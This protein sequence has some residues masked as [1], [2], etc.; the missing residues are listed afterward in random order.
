MS[1]AEPTAISPP[2][3]LSRSIDAVTSWSGRPMASV[4]AV[5]L[6]VADLA[7]GY[8]SGWPT[9]WINGNSAGTGF[10]AIILLFLLQHSTSRGDRALHAK[11]DAQIAVD[12]AID[13]QLIGAECLPEAEIVRE[14]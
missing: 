12:E 6:T 8:L 13:N 1:D 7:W 3:V 2:A 11:L 4:L 5:V 9:N 14:D 10:L